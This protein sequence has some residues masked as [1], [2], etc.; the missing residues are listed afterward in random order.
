MA[1]DDNDKEK[2][3]DKAGPGGGR[4]RHRGTRIARWIGAAVLLAL[5]AVLAAAWWLAGTEGGA[6]SAIALALRQ[7]GGGAI[8]IEGVHGR[9]GG[10]LRLDRVTWKD[11]DQQVIARQVQLEWQ[12]HAL[13]S[14]LLHV[15]MLSA[16]R[17]DVV[18]SVA[19]KDEPL[20][21]P[22]ALRL[23]LRL[24]IDRLQVVQAVLAR[25]PLPLVELG[26]LSLALDYDGARYRARLQ[27]LK[28]RSPDPALPVLGELGGEATLHDIS[29]YVL[30]GRFAIESAATV[31]GKQLGA[32][33]TASLSGTLANL[34]ATLAADLAQ[35][36]APAHI[37]GRFTLRPFSPQPLSASQLTAR[38]IDLSF[39]SAAAPRTSLDADL[40]ADANGRGSLA[41]RNAEAGT[42][43]RNALPLQSLQL[44]FSQQDRRLLFDQLVARLGTARQPAG[45]VNGSGSIAGGALSMALV[46]D[47]LDLSRLDARARK[48]RLSGRADLRHVEGRDEL[49]LALVERAQAQPL[50]FDV[51][52][53]LADQRLT[54]ERARIRVAGGELAATGSVNLDGQQPFAAQGSFSRFSPRALGNFPQVPDML[55]NGNFSLQGARAPTLSGT[56]EFG[57]ADSRL[58]GQP[59]QG[60]GKV[61]LK[62]DM[63]EVPELALQAGDNRLRIAGS[64]SQGRR[65]GELRFDVNAP[66]LDQL[67]RGWRGALLADGTARGTVAAPA[68]EANW[69]AQGLDVPA[70][71]RLQSGSGRISLRLDPRQAFNIGELKTQA[72]LQGLARERQ[73][74]ASVELRMQFAPQPEAPLQIDLQARSLADGARKLDT[75]AIAADGST[76]RHQISVRAAKAQQSLAAAAAG[77]V[78]SL[79]SSPSWHGTLQR[80]DSAGRL[81][82][83]LANPA[84][85]QLS[86]QRQVVEQLRLEV[87]GSVIQI[88]QFA[89]DE[90]GTVTRGRLQRVELARLLELAG[91]SSTVATDLVLDGEWN[92]TLAQALNGRAQLRRVSGDVTVLGASQAVLGLGELQA[93]LEAVNN[94]VELTLGAQGRQLGQVAVRAAAQV[95]SDGGQLGMARNGSISG[96]ARIDMPSIGWAGGLISPLLI[97]EGRLQSDV[98]LA[99]TLAAPRLSGQVRGE[100]LRVFVT[101]PGIDLRQGQ[102]DASFEDDRLLVKNLSFTGGEG[103]LAVTGPLQFAGGQAS[104]QLDLRATRFGLFN[105]SDRRIVVSGNSRIELS[106]RAARVRGG[107]TI[108]SG[109]VDIGKTELPELSDDVVIVG[110]QKKAPTAL[111]PDIDLTIGLGDQL[112]LR[113][114]G[115]DARIVGD[116]R[117]RNTPGAPLQTQGTL[118]VAE[119]SFTAYGKELAIEQG[120]LRFTGAISNPALDILAM[121]RRQDVAAGVSV[122][123]TVLSPRVTLVSEPTVPD[124]EKLSWLVLGH[125]LSGSEG[126]DLSVLQSAAASLLTGSAAA[127]VQGQLSS[128]LGLDTINLSRSQDTLQQRIVTVGKQVSSRLYVSVVQGLET[129][130]SALRLRYTLSPRMTVEA[131]AGT[132][133][134]FSLFYNI[135]FD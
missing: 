60:K 31:D 112:R 20:V 14:G 101:D 29:P 67:G 87:E 50:D 6:R 37:D 121:R 92:L 123:G 36:S 66:R 21:L 130:T 124:A 64:L 32:R 71:G 125:G 28:L 86:A 39:F 98:Q 65:S 11:I 22:A 47:G 110:Q 53:V 4:L 44:R 106:A 128:T 7:Y 8:A 34:Q 2:D 111:A 12:P 97:T 56:L 102:L 41:L 18:T 105:R 115:L 131:E 94:R 91:K 61:M 25:G 103:M 73:S 54:L 43:D 45:T 96:S 114:R 57:I 120:V 85:L 59:L 16:Q 1:S 116:L 81:K 93:K 23:P 55:L 74:V 17:I 78:E 52:A 69:K 58:A 134:V 77:G 33:G 109:L 68:I 133:S 9:L 15:S 88:D 63:L 3:K 95:Q 70:L 10:T 42:L 30:Q 104:G 129:A 49:A 135:T 126:A 5:L 108:D 117:I 80:L 89:H 27:P 48:T 122:R 79:A 40:Q 24:Q 38:G 99:G 13:L 84:L 118:R 51:R 113:G 107:F 46:T 100:A 90:R 19:K 76:S 26:A 75:L 82:A 83:R 35:K 62:G 119:G 72:S 127:G 132:R